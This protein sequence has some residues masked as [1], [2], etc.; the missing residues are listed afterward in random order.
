MRVFF[1]TFIGIVNLLESQNIGVGTLNPHR[2]ALLEIYAGSK[3][4]LF[5][6]MSEFEKNAK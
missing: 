4:F 1:L 2:S 5:P 6:R 3:G